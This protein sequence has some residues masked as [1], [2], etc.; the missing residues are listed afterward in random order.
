MTFSSLLGRDDIPKDAKKIIRSE[1]KR[2]KDIETQLKEK[3]EHFRVIIETSTDAIFQNNLEGII[4]FCSPS[5][6]QILGYSPSEVIGTPFKKYI[7]P[8]HLNQSIRAFKQATS[9]KV[10]NLVERQVCHKNGEI[11]HVEINGAPIVKDGKILGTQGIVRDIT[12]IKRTQNRIRESEKKFRNLAEQSPNM[13]FINQKG[14]IVYTNKRCEELLGYTQE[15]FKSSDFDFLTLVAPEFREKIVSN[16]QKHMKGEEV[17]PIEY[18]IISKNGKRFNTLLT[19]KLIDF[20]GDKGILG[21]VTDITRQKETEIILRKRTHELIMRIKEL[22][23]LHQVSKLLSDPNLEIDEV[24]NLIIDLIPSA[25]QYPDIVCVHLEFERKKYVSANFQNSPWCQSADIFVVKKKVGF[26]R[27]CYLKEKLVSDEGPFLKEERNLIDAIARELGRFIGRVRAELALK[28][29]KEKYQLLIEKLQ[30]GVILEDTESIITFVNPKGAELLGYSENELIGKTWRDLVT[31]EY[32]TIV[33]HESDKRPKGIGSTY[34][35]QILSKNRNVVPVLITASPIF[36]SRGYF[37]GTLVVFTDITILKEAEEKRINFIKMTSHE[38]RNPLA[39]IS[40]YCDF[41]E[42]HDKFIDLERRAEIYNSLRSNVNRLERLTEDISQV[43]R[44]EQG[45]F[46]IEKKR[47]EICSFLQ[48]HFDQYKITLGDQ[49]SYNGCSDYT[50][51]FCL[52]D[53]DR[54]QQVLVNVMNNAIKQTPKDKRRIIVSSEI[55]NDKIRI[56]IKDNGSGI[57]HERLESIFEQFISFSTNYA[58]K[59]TG[60][61][62]YLSKKILEAHKGKI[63]AQ[64]DGLG[65]GSTFIIDLPIIENKKECNS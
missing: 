34:E 12:E 4:T 21:T 15:E 23:C 52:I 20:E 29:A 59:G 25:W 53:P 14:K 18:E 44:I 26:I 16:F 62:L 43:A 28:E 47:I 17:G 64:S 9:G 33:N 63:V 2:I 57:P 7:L 50:H 41:L 46:E 1:M 45:R 31:P 13:I 24:F 10:V 55:F 35:I 61:G 3:E 8:S 39:V 58:T 54:F 42:R 5:I 60:I 32:F 27:V 49:F 22:N 48:S 30:E 11:K 56:L 19:T 36:S 65:Y 6:S 40:A 38:L 51:L 37:S